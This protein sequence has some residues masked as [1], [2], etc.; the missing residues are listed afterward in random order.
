M[1][2]GAELT[3]LGA[4]DLGTEGVGFAVDMG[5]CGILS[6]DKLRFDS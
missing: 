4:M 3:R 1:D 2:W 5:E 6:F